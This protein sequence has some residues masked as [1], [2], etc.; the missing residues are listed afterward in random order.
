MRLKNTIKNTFNTIVSFSINV[1]LTFTLRKVMVENLGYN[2]IG[3]NTFLTSIIG[4]LAL[5]ELGIGQAITYS[6]YKPLSEK[7]NDKIC[8]LLNLFKKIYQVIGGGIFFLSII[9]MYFIKGLIKDDTIKNTALYFFIYS[10]LTVSSYFFSYKEILINADQKG[11]KLIKI[12]TIFNILNKV[13][14]ILVLIY[15]KKYL[16]WLLASCFIMMCNYLY[17]SYFIEKEYKNINFKKYNNYSLKK[18]F[19]L[20]PVIIKNSYTTFI[21]KIS[22]FITYKTDDILITKLIGIVAL[23]KYSNYILVTSLVANFIAGIFWSL[24]SI[25]GN[26]VVEKSKEESFEIWEIL[27]WISFYIATIS[28]FSIFKNINAFLILWIGRETILN[29]LILYVLMIN[30]YIRIIREPLEL[31][32]NGFGIFDGTR[33]IVVLEAVLNLII[34]LLLGY[35]F[36]ILGIILGTLISYL[37]GCFW[38]VPYIT[39][40]NGFQKKQIYYYKSFFKDLAISL[41]SIILSTL[42]LNKIKINNFIYSCILTFIIINSTF[43]FL[44]IKNKNFHKLISKIKTELLYLLKKGS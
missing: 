4:F 39:F 43:L 3:L 26:Y 25:I 10:L 42:I 30:F 18:L 32:R 12:N 1:I 8:E 27:S 14:Q 44:N 31:F 34:S 13:I 22:L 19:S 9:I 35:K 7:N 11:Y 29:N 37:F 2:Y 24:N 17:N 16:Y 21:Y 33:K 41:A 36:G 23:G 28:S 6:L 38:F 15:T 40:K 5:S 20:N